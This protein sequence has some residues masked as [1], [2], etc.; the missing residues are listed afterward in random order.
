MLMVKLFS[1]PYR[2]VMETPWGNT[3]TSNDIGEKAVEINK[4]LK[5]K[6]IRVRKLESVHPYL[7]IWYDTIGG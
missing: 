3:I 6:A 1:L 2:E 4:F 7:A 5:S